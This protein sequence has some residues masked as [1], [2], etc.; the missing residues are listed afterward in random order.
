MSLSSGSPGRVLFWMPSRAAI[1]IAEKRRYGFAA[2]SGQRYS[3]R[4]LF[5]LGL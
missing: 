3:I 5:G 4:R 1:S 2:E